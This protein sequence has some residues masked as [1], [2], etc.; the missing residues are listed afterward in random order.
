MIPAAVVPG[1][2]D[3]H[4][5]KEPIVPIFRHAPLQLIQIHLQ[6]VVGRDHSQRSPSQARHVSDLVVAVMGLGSQINRGSGVQVAKT[7]F[8]VIGERARESDHHRRD[9]RLGSA[10]GERRDGIS[11]EAELLRKPTKRVPFD[12]IGRGRGTPICQLRVIHGDQRVG[13]HRSQRHAGV[14]QTKVARVRDLH[15]P[16]TQHLFNIGNH[17]LERQ[18]LMEVVTRREV[19]SNLFRRHRGQD[20]AVRNISL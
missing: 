1:C 15:L 12:L 7:V 10:T 2:T 13:H 19:S 17:F 9:V 18:R 5:R 6:I 3:D 14:K 16:G 11:R 8:A 20:G 4:E